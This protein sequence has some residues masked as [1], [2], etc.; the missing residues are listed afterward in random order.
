MLLAKVKEMTVYRQTYILLFFSNERT[1]LTLNHSFLEKIQ[2][3]IHEC[4]TVRLVIFFLVV[5]EKDRVFLS[6]AVLF[7]LFFL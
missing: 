4:A 7:L 3:K 1:K 5:G 6:L 2:K